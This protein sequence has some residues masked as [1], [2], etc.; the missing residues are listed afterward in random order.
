MLDLRSEVVA[1][2]LMRVAEAAEFLSQS[3]A[4]VYQLMGRGELPFVK[5]GRAR[6]VPRRAVVEFAASRTFGAHLDQEDLL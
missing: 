5:I 3:R 1:D 4:A 2:G 6:R